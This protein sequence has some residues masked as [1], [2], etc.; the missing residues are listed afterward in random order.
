MTSALQPEKKSP[1]TPLSSCEEDPGMSWVCLRSPPLHPHTWSEHSTLS[2][3]KSMAD[4]GCWF[5]SREL[6]ITTYPSV[7][8][9]SLFRDTSRATWFVIGRLNTKVTEPDTI[10]AKNFCPEQNQKNQKV[11]KFNPIGNELDLQLEMQTK[12]GLLRWFQ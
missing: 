12:L 11:Q 4:S 7:S 5:S 2:W 6:H 3:L 10:S 9:K 8:W 1:D